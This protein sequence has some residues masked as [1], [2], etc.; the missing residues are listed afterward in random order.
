[1]PEAAKGMVSESFSIDGPRDRGKIARSAAIAHQRAFEE[2][3]MD[4]GVI[5]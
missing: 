5:G 3:G 2:T 1:L 4:H